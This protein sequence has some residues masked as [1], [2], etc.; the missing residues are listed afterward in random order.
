M[1]S[2]GGTLAI[3]GFPTL[4]FICL[5]VLLYLNSAGSEVAQVLETSIQCLSSFPSSIN[6]CLLLT[7]ILCLL[8]YLYY[9]TKSQVNINVHVRGMI[10]LIVI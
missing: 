6:T 10:R 4:L 1:L 5:Y 8:L 3:G 2:A 9:I 7:H